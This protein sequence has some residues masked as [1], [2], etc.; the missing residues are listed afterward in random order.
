[1]YSTEQ[2]SRIFGVS[3]A[4]INKWVATG[5]LV[6]IERSTIDRQARIPENTIW[7][8]PTGEQVPVR[9]VVERYIQNQ[10]MKTVQM[11]DQDYTIER[12]K[13]IV[14]TINFFEERHGGTYQRVVEQKG[15]PF[16]TDDWQW[17]RE[18]KEWKYL[19][20]EIDSLQ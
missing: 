14:R 11:D 5:R 3:L 13:E 19:L 20:R 6:G 18:G 16:S 15:D 1:M 12:V 4:T 7:L 10:D 8:S 9:E 2:L 17:G